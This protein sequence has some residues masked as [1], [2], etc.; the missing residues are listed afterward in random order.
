MNNQSNRLIDIASRDVVCLSADA[1][2]GDAAR[3]MAQRRFSCVVIADADSRPVGIVTESNILQ[4]MRAGSSPDTS[5]HIGMSSPVVVMPGDT[6]CLDAYQACTRDGIRHL[7]LVDDG[8]AVIGVVSET[9][10]RMHL[11]LAALAGHRLVV[12]VARRTIPALPPYANLMQ[13]LDLMQAQHET[14]VLVVE[15]DK[16][17]GIVTERDVVKLYARAPESVSV[18]LAEVMTAP[19]LTIPGDATIN[20]A[21]AQMLA[22]KVR[23]LAVVDAAGR[24]LGLVSEH[25]LTQSMVSGLLDEKIEVDEI[26]LRTV[27]DTIPD[28]VWLKDVDGRYLSCNRRFELLFGAKEAQIAGKTDYDFVGKEFAD[29]FREHDRRAMA[30]DKQVINEEWLTFAAGGY[31]GLFETIK[32]P[33]RDSQGKLIGVLGVARDITERERIKLALA[34]SEQEFRTL[35]ENTPDNVIRY[36]RQC[37]VSY[38]NPAMAR[39]IAP[40][41][42]PVVGKLPFETNPDSEQLRGL[43]GLVVQVMESGERLEVEFEIL[44]PDRSLHWH[45][46]IFVAERDNNGEITGALGIGR[47]ITERKRLED[48]LAENELKYRTMFTSAND[49]FFLLD[50]HGKFIECNPKGA[51]MYGLTVAQVIGH[52][53]LEFT[54]ERQ[55]DGRLSSQVFVDKFEQVLRGVSQLVEWQSLRADGTLFDVEI[56]LNGITLG[57]KPCLHAVVRDVTSRKQSMLQLEEYRRRL[58][59]LVVEESTKFRALVEQSLVGIYIIQDGLFRYVNPGMVKMFGYESAD[60]IVDVVP[61]RQFIHDEDQSL[62]AENI[63]RRLDGEVGDLR[64]SFTAHKRDGSTIVVDVHGRR[65]EYQ[66]RPAIIGTLVDITEMRRSK[67][68]LEQMVY[69]KSAELRQSEELLRTLIEAIPDAIEFKD[70]EGRWLESNSAARAAFDLD[71][72]T[73]RG[74]SD[75]ELAEMADTHN[76][77]ALLQCAATDQQAWQAGGMTRLQEV[78]PMPNG[79][80]LTFDVIK[81]PLFQ[82]DGSRKGLVIVGRDISELKRAEAGLRIAASVF[83]NTQEAITITDANNIIVDVNPAFTR[84]TGYSRSEVLGKNPKMLSSGRQDPMFYAEMW[85]SLK[86]KHA[87][88]GEIWNRRKNGEVYAELLSISAIC[89]DAGEVQRHVGVF[90][91]IT[92]FKDHEAELSRAANY[93]LLTGVPNR[94]LLADRLRQAIV[95]AQRGGKMLAICYIDLDGFKTVN[96]LYGHGTGDLLLIEITLRLHEVLRAGDTLARLGGDEFVVL[97]NDIGHETECFQILERIMQTIS[98][99]M[100]ISEHHIV[101]SASIGVT[102]Y[103]NDNEDGD[104]LLRHADQAMYVAKQT[105]KNRYHAYDVVNDQLVRSLREFRLR[106]Q[107]G[108]ENNE[109]ELFYQPKLE[110]ATNSVVGVEALIRWNHPERGLLQP[111]DF[112]PLIENSEIETHLGI[113][114]LDTALDQLHAWERAGVSMEVSIN[115]AARHLQSPDFVDELQRKMAQYPKLEHGRLQIEVLETAALEDMGQSSAVIEACRKLGVTFALDDFGTGYSSLVYLR[116]LSADTLKIDQSFVQDMATNEADRAIVQGVIALAKTFGRKTV[117]EGMEDPALLQTLT[118]MGCGYVQGYGI[119][120]PM[121]AKDFIDWYRQRNAKF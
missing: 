87:W 24:T 6:D 74:K 84:I 108:F 7:V 50:E 75:A 63:R 25:D 45:H 115:I 86:E 89:D 62:V 113:W 83:D 49:G 117:A 78:M 42:L 114:V 40:E 116:K 98:A 1:T 43:Q 35:A 110:L 18:A 8:G 104:T 33:M 92:Y 103:P 106:I 38:V 96:D 120:H 100:P 112:L 58:E 11:N 101:V 111:A 118:D 32:T 70:G 66:G 80:K 44:H 48:A 69:V 53:P 109:F 47:D 41:F 72:L 81:V 51:D 4:A 73:S 29:S 56:T 57:G 12:A 107:R 20:Q 36:D 91:D 68:E 2:L 61:L 27:V 102:F 31:H 90:S 88:R 71:V 21:A 76:K 30:L 67:E 121:P 23:H 93:D 105:G 79:D 59:G 94:R 46:V 26:L 55:P 77:A 19:V 34:A 54:P 14:C 5:L 9:D 60:G 10:F 65:I 16:P 99:P 64:Y 97:F 39:T 52:S 37:R 17:A 13:A 22:H 85:R 82:D 95:H 28:L 119:A 15:G 3:L